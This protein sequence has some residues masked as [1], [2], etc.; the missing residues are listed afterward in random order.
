MPHRWLLPF[1]AAL[2]LAGCASATAPL[3]APDVYRLVSIDGRLLPTGTTIA[4]NANGVTILAEWL[5]LDHKGTATRQ[6]IV[7]G[8]APSTSLTYTLQYA[9]SLVDSVV[10]LGQQT[11][12]PNALCVRHIPEQGR[13]TA[14]GTLSLTSAGA[15]PVFLYQL[16]IPD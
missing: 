15:P 4:P 2:A 11:C 5:I 7:P 9:Y 12:A 16:S 13:L 6:R 8:T 14:T 1:I 3:T 10:T